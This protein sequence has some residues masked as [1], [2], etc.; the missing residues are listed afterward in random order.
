[1]TFLLV[2]LCLLRD[3]AAQAQTTPPASPGGRAGAYMVYDAARAETLLFGGWTRAAAGSDLTYPDDLWA[4]NGER[5]RKLE[6]PPGSARPVGR[7]APVMAYDAARKRLVMFGGR[8]SEE[9][10]PPN[11]YSDVWEWDGAR[12]HQ[13]P[14]SGMPRLLH[15]TAI[16]DPARHRVVVYGGGLV[17]GTGQFS[18]F[19]RT[20]WEW[21]GA[22]WTAR[23]SSG[24]PDL[25][26]AAATV[27]SDG[28]LIFMMG[29]AGVNRAAPNAASR[30]WAWSGSAWK[31]LAEGPAFN[32]LQA[33]SGGPDGS[34]YF[35]QSWEDWRTSPITH[36]RDA[37]GV[38]QHLEG[39][40]NPGIRNTQAAAWDARRN[41]LVLYGGTTRD[42][43]LPADT[44][45]FDGRNWLKR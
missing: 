21:D 11:W 2:A 37:R 4:W 9:G 36:V 33:A 23:D 7:D 35:Y 18:G 42:N 5:W 14:G 45:E 43:Q 28:S 16:Y 30:L 12:W 10:A 6:P 19:S 20:L 1:M 3:V 15:P 26:P 29:Q 41:R 27:A 25:V 44:W 22:K 34:L 38:W 13:I 39:M 32:N 8:R 40:P 17:S 31:D 24:P